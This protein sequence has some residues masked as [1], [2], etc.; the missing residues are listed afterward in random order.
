MRNGHPD[1][2]PTADRVLRLLVLTGRAARHLKLS[3]ARMACAWGTD[4]KEP[5][6]LPT[7]ERRLKEAGEAWQR[8]QECLTRLERRALRLLAY[9]KKARARRRPKWPQR[10]GPGW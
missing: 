2:P 4:P 7:T 8:A 10:D 5:R 1:G 6:R 9:L 3:L